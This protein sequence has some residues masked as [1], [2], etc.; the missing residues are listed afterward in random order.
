[1][2][3]ES[4]K[5]DGSIEHVNEIKLDNIVVSEASKAYL[6]REVDKENKVGIFKTYKDIVQRVSEIIHEINPKYQ[7]PHM[8]VSTVIESAHCQRFFADHLPKLT[9]AG[10][11]EDSI[12]NYSVDLVFKTIE[13]E[14]TE[15]ISS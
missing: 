10:M 13:I 8:L 4:I 9:D 6:T 1:M 15:K 7:Y 3:T 12:P 11:G 5:E 2:L 14:Q